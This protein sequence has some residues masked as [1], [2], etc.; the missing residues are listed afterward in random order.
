MQ[1][2]NAPFQQALT[3]EPNDFSVSITY[4]GGGLDTTSFYAPNGI[5]VDGNGNVWVAN[6]TT[7]SVTVFNPAG[8]VL[9]GTNG[10]AETGLSNPT[11]L[12]IDIYGNAW[13]ANY[14]SDTI[15]GFKPNGGSFILPGL[16]GG[17]L[18]APYGIA[19]D[20]VG[21]LWIANNGGNDLSEFNTASIAGNALSAFGWLPR[22]LDLSSGRCRHRH[23]WQC[24]D[25]ELWFADNL[26][27][28]SDS[29]GTQNTDPSGYA[30]GGMNAPYGIAIDCTGNIWVSDQGGNGSL[31]EFNSSGTAVSPTG[32]YVNGGLDS[33]SGLAI[34]G[35]GN[36]WIAN[37]FSSNPNFNGSI[38]EFNSS[39]MPISGAN[40]YVGSGINQPYSL[41]VDP[42]GNV[43]V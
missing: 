27:V 10:Y 9:S 40:G 35:L 8:A 26:L 21:H 6:Y 43:W 36:I 7:S 25:G 33:P 32:G 38:S 12:A 15:S 39:G 30:S 31:T 5:A 23:V 14:N 22:G 19:I 29:S 37:F 1:V 3:T 13:V 17:G 28:E 41:A 20:T 18:N 11:S 34:D 16:V 2:P 42:S 4:T 24:V